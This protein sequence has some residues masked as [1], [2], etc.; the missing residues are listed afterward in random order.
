MLKYTGHPLV[1][2]GAA[3]IAAFV[4][5]SDP[6]WVTRSDLDS[7]ARFMAENYTAPPFQSFIQGA[8]FFNSGYS[9]PGIKARRSDYYGPILYAYQSTPMG[10]ADPCVFCG[11]RS[12]QHLARDYFPLLTGRGV[13]N[14][15][16][17]GR[18]GL[19]ICGACLICV[20]ALP[21]GCARCSGK[22]L[23]VHSDSFALMQNVASEFLQQNR[24]ALALAQASD[25]VKKV[26]AR[27]LL[28]ETLLAVEIQRRQQL[29]ERPPCSVT[30]YHLTNSG[31]SNPLDARNPPLEIYHLPLEMIGFLSD[32]ASPG[33]KT[34]WNAIAQ[35]AW[36]LSKPAKS[37]TPKEGEQADSRPRKNMLYEDLFRL[38]SNAR[39]F[40]RQYLLRIPT[41][42]RFEDD[43]R[44][45]Y[46]LRD[47]AE[48]VSWKLTEL[49][50]RKVM[51]M[52]KDRVQEIRGLGDRLA[53]YVNDENDRRFFTTF[54]A[55]QRNYNVFRNALL[56]ANV[57]HV[58]RGN[59]PLITLDPYITVFEE[60][61][62]VARPDWRLARDLVLIR[63]VERL[64]QF[65]WIGKNPDAIPEVSDEETSAA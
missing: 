46:S 8:V 34:E 11:A 25:V 2:V 17:L 21:L 20:Q 38:P 61:D 47:E 57:A 37:K 58:K 27:T 53:A 15:F 3:T 10:D 56:K 40:I 26:S 30:A 41:R 39:A 62:E 42:T 44:R 13:I 51:T 45:S 54:Y 9:N 1:D 12:V 5:K 35:R 14:F 4:H 60:G 23:V 7:V 55:E 29:E 33:Y 64:Y 48:L 31:Q 43:P 32:M 16:P 24:D 65:G 28:V 18:S 50:L 63:M 6:G 19:P 22:L 49:F 59:P 36:R 52:D